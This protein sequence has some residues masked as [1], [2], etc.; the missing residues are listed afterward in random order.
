MAIISSFAFERLRTRTRL[1]EKSAS[2]GKEKGAATRID[3]ALVVAAPVTR[4]VAPAGTRHGAALLPRYLASGDRRLKRVL[5]GGGRWACRPRRMRNAALSF[6]S[7]GATVILSLVE[8]HP[9]RRAA[10]EHSPS[11]DL[12]L[13]LK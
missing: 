11:V 12:Q 2:S 5:V 9:V 4:P 8:A 13:Q 1:S 6:C 7:N 10:I 3:H